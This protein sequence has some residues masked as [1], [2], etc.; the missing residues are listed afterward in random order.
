MPLRARRPAY[1]LG[2]VI[3]TTLFFTLVYNTGMAVWEGRSQPLYRS[4]EVVVQSFTTTGY[5]EDAP[6]RT[7]QMNALVIAM[8]LTGIGL[9]LTAVDVFAV[10]WLRTALAPRAPESIDDHSDHVIIC[11]HTPRTDAFISELE[12]RGREYVLVEA[13]E[14]R[15]GDLHEEGYRV[16]HADPESADGLRAANVESAL[17]V[18]ADADDDTNASIALAARDAD[19]D[20]RI[21]TL[22]EDADLAR[23]HRAAGANDVLS[24]RQLLGSSLAQQVPTAVTTDVDSGVEVGDDFELVELTVAADSDLHGRTFGEA[25]LRE[26]FGVNVIGAWFD[27]DFETPIDAR[28]EL[29]ARTRL[30]VA[31]ESAQ[32]Q[33]LKEA[34]ASTVRRFGPQRIVIAGY[35]DSGQ[36][37]ADALSST[38]TRV[39]VLDVEDGEGVDVVGDARDPDTLDEAGITNAS[40]LIVTVGD[41]TTAIFATLIARELNPDLYVVVRANEEADVQKLYRAGGDYVQS[42]ATVSGRM[43]ASTVFENEEVLAY[44]KQVSVVRLPAGD[45]AGSTIAD[46]RVRTETG[47]TVVAIVRDDRTIVDFDPETFTFEVDDEVVI[48]GTDEATTRFESQFGV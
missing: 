47:C 22:V 27:G 23:Y 36:A 40:A 2:L 44:D 34:T 1:Y 15:A 37:A 5:G 10:P 26:R 11:A 14:D 17:A 3:A 8:Q 29:T 21:I 7:P 25:R 12:A 48:A 39:T 13:D 31:G 35:G 46:E 6:W 9:I 24:P 20:V 16:V 19:S 4:L 38:G 42:L 30:L 45:L 41:D 33:A 18:V 32:V 43:L 28:D